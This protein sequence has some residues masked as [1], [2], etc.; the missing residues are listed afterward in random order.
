MKSRAE[1]EA[2]VIAELDRLR[3]HD[4]AGFREAMEFLAALVKRSSDRR[5]KVGS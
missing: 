4:R 5:G 1:R 2:V 3:K